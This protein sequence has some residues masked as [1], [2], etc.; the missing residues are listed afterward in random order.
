MCLPK[1]E[2]ILQWAK[3]NPKAQGEL[4]NYLWENYSDRFHVWSWYKKYHIHGQYNG[5]KPTWRKQ[6][7]QEYL[8]KESLKG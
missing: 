1:F 8:F 5:R 3:R 6:R 2:P 7:K 4:R